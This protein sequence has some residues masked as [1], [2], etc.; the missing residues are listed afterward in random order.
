MLSK[1]NWG[2]E[3]SVRCQPPEGQL[4]RDWLGTGLPGRMASDFLS[5]VLFLS[6]YFVLSLIY[7]IVIVLT[8][9]SPHFCFSYFYLLSCWG[10]CGEV[11]VAVGVLGCWLGSTHPTL[12]AVDKK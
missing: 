6:Y 8:N 7:S 1:K 3:G 5:R 11:K 4:L 2:R 10:Q 12:M 9:K